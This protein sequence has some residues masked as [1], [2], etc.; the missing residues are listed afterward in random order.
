MWGPYVS[1][2]FDILRNPLS[3]SASMVLTS[4]L[5]DPFAWHDGLLVNLAYSNTASDKSL[6]R[7]ELEAKFDRSFVRAY[8]KPQAARSKLSNR[9]HGAIS[10]RCSLIAHYCLPMVAF[11]KSLQE[12]L[13]MCSAIFKPQTWPTLSTSKQP[14]IAF[15]SFW[16]PKSVWMSFC[17]K[18]PEFASQSQSTFTTKL[19]TPAR[20]ACLSHDFWCWSGVLL[21]CALAWI[22]SWA[23]ISQNQFRCTDTHALTL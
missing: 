3:A 16:S 20:S 17:T 12:C 21:L 8:P 6:V 7:F 23:S 10:L 18:G 9:T 15:H 14:R 1:M 19:Q 4:P 22:L 5:L 2:F 13:E 11:R